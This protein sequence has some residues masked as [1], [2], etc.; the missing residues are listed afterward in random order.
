MEEA[1]KSINSG[2]RRP[3]LI[4]MEHEELH[5]NLRVSSEKRTRRERDLFNYIENREI[6]RNSALGLRYGSFPF[7]MYFPRNNLRS[8]KYLASCPL[9]TSSR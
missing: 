1:F 4:I 3:H 8:H 9:Y 2:G 5:G 6:Y 7:M